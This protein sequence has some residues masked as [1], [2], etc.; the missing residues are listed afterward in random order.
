[1]RERGAFTHPNPKRPG[2][3]LSWRNMQGVRPQTAQSRERDR[4]VALIRLLL[5]DYP[6]TTEANIAVTWGVGIKT[7]RQYLAM[8]KG[9]E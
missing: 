2:I 6:E 7:A 9:L 1:M 5:V 3:A 4:R 8:A